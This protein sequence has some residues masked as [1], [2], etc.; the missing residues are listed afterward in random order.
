MKRNC[1]GLF[2]GALGCVLAVQLQAAEAPRNTA[3]V[4]YSF[5]SGTDAAVP[6]AGLL[7]VKGTLY[8]TT[9]LGGTHDKGALFA[10]DASADT[11]TVVYSF[12]SQPHCADGG[13][14]LAGLID[15]K[16]T[17]YG[18]TS[19]GGTS[20]GGTVFALAPGTGAE[21]VVYSFCDQ[22]NCTDGQYPEAGL[23][24]VK[25][26]LYGTTQKGG[27]SGGGTVFS[28]DTNTGTETVV[29]SFCSQ[30]DCADGKYPMAS[31]ID[32]QGTLYGTTQVGGAAGGGTVFALDPGTGRQT[33][34]YSFCSQKG[35]TDGQYPLASVINVKGT[36]YG[37]TY[38][39]GSSGSHGAVFALDPDTG[40]ETVLYSFCGQLNCAD[41][42]F[43][44]AGVTDVNGM[45]YGTTGYGGRF[46][47]GIVFSLDPGT[48][49]ANVLYDFCTQRN[50]TDGAYPEAPLIDANGTLYGTTSMGGSCCGDNVG[51]GTAVAIKIR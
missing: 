27:A 8:G 14:P 29:Y 26:T 28:I 37:T 39:G 49:A 41:G 1:V 43:P 31:L 5:G 46:N 42:E 32:V 33:V 22:Q 47:G 30:Q 20:G 2:S 50:C 16:G 17:L 6:H 44:F 25:G 24:D 11:E 18:T 13:Y 19:K 21:T 10:I 23:I 35:C 38:G 9:D 12:C 15:V 48:G 45:L 7:D 3:E 34:A 36:L 4:L 40:T 51:Y